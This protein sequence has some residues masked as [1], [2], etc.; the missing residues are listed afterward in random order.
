LRPRRHARLLRRGDRA[1][2]G[3]DA[4]AQ[5]HRERFPAGGRLP[6]PD[7]RRDD[8]VRAAGAALPPAAAGRN[9]ARRDRR[10]GGRGGVR[11]DGRRTDE[12]RPLEI[13]V[14]FLDNPQG[15]ARISVG[16]TRVLCTASI[17]E[18]VPRWLK[19]SGRGWMTAEYGLLPA[20]TGES[21]WGG[22]RAGRGKGGGREGGG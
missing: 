2:G 6:I 11:E 3:G 1:R 9:R 8:A 15:S 4:G 13:T 10:A 22:G 5:G 20:S 18:G 21:T 16:K 7:D 19:G 14:D 17:E 12:L